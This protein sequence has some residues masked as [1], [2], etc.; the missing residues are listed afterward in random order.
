M[1]VE[2]RCTL[3]PTI[4]TIYPTY[5]LK[6]SLYYASVIVWATQPFQVS[7]SRVNLTFLR[8]VLSAYMATVKCCRVLHHCVIICCW[9]SGTIPCML[10]TLALGWWGRN[11]CYIFH[12]NCLT[13]EQFQ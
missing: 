6:Q 3:V 9:S 5:P 10:L 2:R 7:F 12:S 13:D 8:L 11:W 4:L 1:Y